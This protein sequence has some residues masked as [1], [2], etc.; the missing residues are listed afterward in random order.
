MT[1]LLTPRLLAAA[2][3]SIGA[4]LVPSAG[5]ASLGSLLTPVALVTGK[6]TPCS[7]RVLSQP[8][9]AWHDTASY[10][11]APGGSFESGAPGWTLTGG[12]SVQVG[13]NTFLSSGSSLA[14][15]TGASAT[16]PVICVD[17]GSPTLRAFTNAQHGTV[18]VSVVAAGLAIP[19]GVIS[20]SGSWQPTPAM[21][22]LTNTL[23]ILSATGTTT[24]SFRFTAV[25][26]D[27][28]V[29]DVYVDPYRR[30]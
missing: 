30:T 4:I 3:L 13:G 11:P 15:P 16:T 6:A 26:G 27:A 12:A 29:D 7:G 5:A 25:G 14:L 23:G 18:V 22:F 20:E 17:L 24:A 1:K 19:V 2:V 10:F 8:F 9:A 21:L 28:Q